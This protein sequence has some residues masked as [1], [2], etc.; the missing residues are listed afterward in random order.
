MTHKHQWA[1]DS[2]W[3]DGVLEEQC[4]CGA[5]REVFT[6]G[7]PEFGYVIRHFARDGQLSICRAV[8]VVHKMAHK[9]TS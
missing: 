7:N 4:A 5:R 6:V 2:V 1:D 8:L 3:A 9:F